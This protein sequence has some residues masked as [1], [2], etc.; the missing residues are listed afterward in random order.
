MHTKGILATVT[1]PEVTR[2]FGSLRSTYMQN[3]RK[4]LDS[5]RSAMGDDEVSF[6]DFSLL[7]SCGRNIL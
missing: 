5:T 1:E 6:E 7:M 2:K 3:K 4:V